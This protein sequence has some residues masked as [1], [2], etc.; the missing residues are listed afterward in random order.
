M[1]FLTFIF[2]FFN[3]SVIPKE[4]VFTLKVILILYSFKKFAISAQNCCTCKHSQN[5]LFIVSI[6]IMQ[7]SHNADVAVLHFSNNVFDGMIL[8]MKTYHENIS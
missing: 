6:S 7:K 8:I 5:K 2:G 1:K 3:C 4:T